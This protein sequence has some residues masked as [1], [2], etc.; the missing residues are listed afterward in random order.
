MDTKVLLRCNKMEHTENSSAAEKA[1]H[2][3]VKGDRIVVK[4]KVEAVK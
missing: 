2:A 4:V 3:E 1:A